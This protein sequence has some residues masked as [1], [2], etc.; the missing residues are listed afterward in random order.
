VAQYNRDGQAGAQGPQLD[1]SAL[2]DYRRVVA[3]S[4]RKRLSYFVILIGPMLVAIFEVPTC[5]NTDWA[6]MRRSLKL[7]HPASVFFRSIMS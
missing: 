7:T 6:I 4:D 2:S 5:L 1:K 3:L